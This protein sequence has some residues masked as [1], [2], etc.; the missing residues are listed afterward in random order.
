[1]YFL[2]LLALKTLDLFI[3]KLC[4]SFPNLVEKKSKLL[5][6]RDSLFLFTNS[7]IEYKFVMICK[8]RPYDAFSLNSGPV[9]FALIFLADDLLYW[10]LHKQ[11]HTPRLFWIHKH[12]HMEKSPQMGYLDA[13]N[14]H[15]LEQILALSC[16]WIAFNFAQAAV[17]LHEVT[18]LV[19]MLFYATVSILNHTGRDVKWIG[20]SVKHHITHHQKNVCNFCQYF[21]IL[22][23]VLGTSA[24]QRLLPVP[25][26]S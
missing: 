2:K 5:S 20:Y 17:G 11:L 15:P 16:L 6:A 12:H 9:A 4:A 1:M 8:Q 3:C 19:F 22:D 18:V 23:Q 14:E 7:L 24:S 26:P 10:I 13:G 21:H 25:K